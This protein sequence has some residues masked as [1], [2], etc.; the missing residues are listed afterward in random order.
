[1]AAPSLFA[2]S[3]AARLAQIEPERRQFK[4]A[5]RKSLLMAALTIVL[6]IVFFSG[7]TA[8][9]VWAAGAFASQRPAV[10]IVAVL[11]VWAVLS[12]ALYHCMDRAT[13]LG[14]P[15]MAAL[16]AAFNE[17]L[18]LPALREALPRC[19]ASAGPLIGLEGIRASRLFH[20]RHN[21][22]LSTC[23]FSGEAAGSGFR[24][25]VLRLAYRQPGK[26]LHPGI[27]PM[28]EV[29]S[30]HRRGYGFSGILVHLERQTPFTTTVR[31][32]DPAYQN[33]PWGFETARAHDIVRSRSGDP[34][35][36]EAFLVLLDQGQTAAP[37]IPDALRR[38]CFELRE[39]FGLPVFLSF[40]GTGTY[41]AIAT[42]DGRL[43]MQ[44]EHLEEPAAES[45]AKEIS[46]INKVPAAVE[47]LSSALH[48]G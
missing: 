48:A 46:V 22:M 42:G 8:G 11:A 1:M 47:S 3:L 4:A 44:L 7:G 12:Y 24:A 18:L 20:S 30:H 34:V 28:G 10:L 32:A 31:L 13:K 19:Q 41:L 14:E 38:L 26:P 9:A 40:T 21:R 25:T 16:Q 5:S 45:L 39:L 36:D 17:R 15:A 6:A 27:G 33:S 43:P 23:G 35:F 29:R 2:P 37:P